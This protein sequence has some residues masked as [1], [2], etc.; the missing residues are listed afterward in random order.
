MNLAEL[1]QYKKKTD[2]QGDWVPANA[3]T[4]KPFKTRTGRTLLYCWQPKTGKHA[5]LDCGTDLILSDEEAALAMGM[6]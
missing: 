6:Q 5:C 1:L 4:E 2:E 3:G